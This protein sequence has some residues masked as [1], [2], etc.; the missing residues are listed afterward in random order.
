M[1]KLG[2]DYIAITEDNLR[3]ENLLSLS[4]VHL[5][6][7]NFFSPTEEKIKTTLGLYPKTNRYVIE[8]NIR[9]Y[10]NV[11]KRTNKKY[12]V[13]NLSGVGFVSFFRKNNKVLLNIE[14][15]S[16]FEKQFVLSVCLEDVLRNIEVIQ[17]NYED[18]VSA[19]EIFEKWNGNVIINNETNWVR[20]FSG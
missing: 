17:L 8:D 2:S 16:I 13:M 5:I 7:L 10:N 9:I 3:D 12:Y 19:E 20:T 1:T 4:R 18:F 6:K 15:L 11:L 14:N